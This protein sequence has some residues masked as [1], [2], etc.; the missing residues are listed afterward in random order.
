MNLRVLTARLDLGEKYG[1]AD[2]RAFQSNSSSVW[3][4]A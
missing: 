3:R 1:D 4:A 2:G